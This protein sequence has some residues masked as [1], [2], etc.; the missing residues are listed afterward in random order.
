MWEILLSSFKTSPFYLRLRE[1][2]II[3]EEKFGKNKEII[4]KYHILDICEKENTVRYSL[5]G[6]DDFEYSSPFKYLSKSFIEQLLKQI[7]DNTS[8]SDE[9]IAEMA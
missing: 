5:I 4:K 6:C 1:T 3:V 9:E 8:L 2:N 7:N